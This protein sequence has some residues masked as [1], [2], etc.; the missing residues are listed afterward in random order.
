MKGTYTLTNEVGFSLTH[1][2][3]LFCF[4]FHQGAQRSPCV[5]RLI[6]TN[7]TSLFFFVTEAVCRKNVELSEVERGNTST[8]GLDKKQRRSVE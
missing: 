2:S 8:T 3:F 1:N 7:Y 6:Q 4:F 5:V